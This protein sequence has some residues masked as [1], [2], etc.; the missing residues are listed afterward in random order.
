LLPATCESCNV[1]SFILNPSI[2]HTH[3]GS[4]LPKWASHTPQIKEPT[5]KK[6]KYSCFLLM[7]MFSV[8]K[9]LMQ[10]LRLCNVPEKEIVFLLF[11]LK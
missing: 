8:S 9:L 11:H 1:Q 10:Q 5:D 2:K 6:H 4:I 7:L 3:N